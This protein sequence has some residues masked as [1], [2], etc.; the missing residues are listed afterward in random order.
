MIAPPEWA[1]MKFARVLATVLVALAA[2][3]PAAAQTATSASVTAEASN[4][5]VATHQ[6]LVDRYC[7]ACHNERMAGRGTV[8]FAFDGLDLADVGADGR[9]ESEGARTLVETEVVAVGGR[10]VVTPQGT[11]RQ[12]VQRFEHL[13][14]ADPVEQEHAPLRDDR[15]GEPLAD[16]AAP[17]RGRPIPGPTG[18]QRGAAVAPVALGTQVL[19][20][21]LG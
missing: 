14:V 19:R 18:A 21:A 15:P 1:I 8:P 7:V 4:A 16:G 2:A 6:A 3:N 17:Q 12:G 5:P 9:V 13:A 10:V 20:P 11:A